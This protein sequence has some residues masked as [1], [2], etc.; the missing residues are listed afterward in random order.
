MARLSRQSPVELGSIFSEDP[1]DDVLQ[2]FFR[3]MR[4]AQPQETRSLAPPVEI[5]E[6]GRD[7]VVTAELPGVNKDNIEVALQDGVLNI[8]AE[9]KPEES[10]EDDH[11]LRQER[12]FGAYHR[13]LRF[14]VQIDEG[15]I[16]ASYK[17]G[18]LKLVLPKAVELGPKRIAVEVK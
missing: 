7:Y 17:D 11:V 8:S 18:L 9:C 14:D 1:L 2:G 16:S 13:R 3:P 12:R 4:V 6:R 15:N 5:I 10:T